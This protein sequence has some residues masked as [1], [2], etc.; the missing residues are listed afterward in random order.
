MMIFMRILEI[1]TNGD[2]GGDQFKCDDP[3]RVVLIAVMMKSIMLLVSMVLLDLV[4]A[5]AVVIL[6]IVII[7]ILP[8]I[9]LEYRIRDNDL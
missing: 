6:V 9:R 5:T 7:I 2:N 4:I 8:M 1:M 3:N